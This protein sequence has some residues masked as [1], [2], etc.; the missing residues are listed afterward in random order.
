MADESHVIIAGFGLPGRV[1]AE[2]LDDRKIAYSVI[3]LNAETVR[4]C[5]QVGIEIV[6]GDVRQPEVLKRAGIDKASLVCLTFPDDSMVIDAVR[7]ARQLN[8][9]VKII[10]RCTFVS[11]GFQ[12]TQLGA[13]DV[14][15]AEQVVAREFSRQIETFLTMKDMTG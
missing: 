14:V 7:T 11:G 4:R 6:F 13:T 8:P 10:A 1:I 12:A 5:S 2:A 9:H 15:I 3:E